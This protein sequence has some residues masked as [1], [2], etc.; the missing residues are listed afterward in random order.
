MTFSEKDTIPANF[1]QSEATDRFDDRGRNINYNLIAEHLSGTR[2]LDK[3]IDDFKAD[4]TWTVDA[5]FLSKKYRLE[6][7]EAGRQSWADGVVD[8]GTLSQTIDQSTEQ[9][10]KLMSGETRGALQDNAGWNFLANAQGFI[11]NLSPLPWAINFNNQLGKYIG[12]S[13]RSAIDTLLQSASAGETSEETL[14][15]IITDFA[16]TDENKFHLAWYMAERS[17]VSEE[18]QR[19]KY[20]DKLNLAKIDTFNMINSMGDLCG[21]SDETKA[22]AHEQVELTGFTGFDHLFYGVTIEDNGT[23]GDYMPGFLRIEVKFNGDPSSPEDSLQPDETIQH[24][25]LHASSAQS[26]DNSIGLRLS[27][28]E[29]REVNE[30]MTEFLSRTSMGDIVTTEDGSIISLRPTGYPNETATMAYIAE[31][32]PEAFSC[33]FKAYYGEV[34]D[35]QG[36]AFSLNIFYSYL[37]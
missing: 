30:A 11:S 37:A 1:L 24:E 29:G 3:I 15:Q 10:A 32:F 4:R 6:I 20:Q 25:L 16:R 31:N 5:A 12:V 22:R 27:S 9:F 19:E 2:D 23:A 36:L 13:D 17:L 7:A 8:P 18:Y 34:P 26:I 14:R 28:G 21:L 35:K 33:L